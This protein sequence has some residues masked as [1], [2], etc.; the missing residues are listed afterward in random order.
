MKRST[1]VSVSVALILTGAALVTWA[2]T[3]RHA[4]TKYEV[5]ERV[6]VDIPEDDLLAQAGFYEGSAE[7]RI[8]RTDG[9]HMGLFPVPQGLF[10]KHMVSVMTVVL[11]VWILFGIVTWRLRGPRRASAQGVSDSV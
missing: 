11:P 5:V 6:E 10:D 7:V 9:F 1:A 8:V 4:Y 2:A 3:G